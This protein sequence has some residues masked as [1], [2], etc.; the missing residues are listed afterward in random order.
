MFSRRSTS[1]AALESRPRI[2]KVADE[3]ADHFDLIGIVA[4]NL[5][6]GELIFDQYHQFKAIEPVGSEIVTEV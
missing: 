1:C 3:I 4:R 2:I 6:A 5:H